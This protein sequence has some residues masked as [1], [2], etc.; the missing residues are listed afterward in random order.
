MAEATETCLREIE[1]EIP[2]ERVQKE[3]KKVVREFARV[4]RIPGFRPGKAPADLIRRRFWDDIRGEVLQNLLP[5]TLEAALKEKSYHPLSRPEVLDLKFEHDQP[6]R[7]KASFEI[8][9]EFELGKYKGLVAPKGKIELTEEHIEEE[10]ARLR[11]QQAT[12]EPVE[13]RAAKGGDTVVADLEGTFLKPEGA[14]R[15]PLK[16]E[17]AEIHLGSEQTLAGFSEGLTGAKNGEE[18]RFT[19]DYPGDYHEASLAGASVTFTAKLLALRRKVLP[20]LNDEFARAAGD[21]KN[22][23]GLRKAVRE[24]MEESRAAWEKKVTEQNVLDALIA[25]HSFP[26]PEVLVE[27]QLNSRLERQVRSLLSQGLDPRTVDVDWK[28]IRS[29]QR[30]GAVREVR[31]GL[32]LERIA[33]TESLEP[34][35][36]DIQKEIE[37]LAAQASQEAG[38]LKA[39]LTKEGGLDRIKNAVRSDKVAEFLISHA[40]LT[41]KDAD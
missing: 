3:T 27:Q 9:P 39:R 21:Y 29:E 17:N 10:L 12:Y 20:E 18:R 19:V 36:A 14:A 15:E 7:Y 38:A 6:V 16:L 40:K 37:R 2:A 32:L 1:V 24:R 34:S 13:G 25:E 31:L 28:K 41:T 22:L 11:E 26:V 35:E 5:E 23:K 4:A 8:M 33:Q 30:P